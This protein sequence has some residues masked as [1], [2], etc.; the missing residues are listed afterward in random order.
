[1]QTKV[2]LTYHFVPSTL[3]CGRRKRWQIPLHVITHTPV[4]PIFSP[5]ADP[6]F[7]TDS[8]KLRNQCSNISLLMCVAPSQFLHLAK[9]PFLICKPEVNRPA[10]ESRGETEWGG[11]CW[12][13]R[14]RRTTGT[15]YIMPLLNAIHPQPP[16]LPLL[17]VQDARGALCETM[18][19]HPP[20]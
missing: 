10:S 5:H 9:P 2:K 6:K 16:S 19:T 13:P 7:Q 3:S 8:F 4:P 20:T 17:H 18:V 14:P 1:M 15:R 12:R 11:E